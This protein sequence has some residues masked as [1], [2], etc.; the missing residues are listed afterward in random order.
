MTQQPQIKYRHDYRAPDYTITDI[1]L[2][3]EL[4]AATTRVTAVS[5]VKRL[6]QADVPLRLDGEDLTLISI[7]V[8]GQPWSHYQLEERAL[9]LNQ[10]PA[11]FTLKNR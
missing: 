8:D 10:L 2:T 11:T 1:D 6:A 9:V 7:E 3:F 5:R 4:D